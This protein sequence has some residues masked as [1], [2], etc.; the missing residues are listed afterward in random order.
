M[1]KLARKMRSGRFKTYMHLSKTYS[2]VLEG[3]LTVLGAES[4]DFLRQKNRRSTRIA[5]WE[6]L[7]EMVQKYSSHFRTDYWD[8][9]FVK[10][11]NYKRKRSSQLPCN[12]PLHDLH[13][14]LRP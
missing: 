13:R 5:Y 7:K 1:K 8:S 3:V 14:Y 11:W 6:K 12:D 10:A 9:S 2:H 4:E